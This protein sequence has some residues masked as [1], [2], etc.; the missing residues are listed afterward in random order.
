MA[1]SALHGVRLVLDQQLAQAIEVLDEFLTMED[2]L[3]VEGLEGDQ[4]FSQQLLGDRNV[5]DSLV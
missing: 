2:L 1:I 3:L 4:R 5:A